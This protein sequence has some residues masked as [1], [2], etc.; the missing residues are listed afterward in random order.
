M[1]TPRRAAIGSALVFAASGAILGAWVSRLPALRD[2]LHATPGQLGTA[3]LAFGVGTLASMPLTGRVVR[4]VGSRVVVAVDALLACAVLA[5]VGRVDTLTELTVAMFVLG[6]FYGSWDVGM[7]VQGST[8]DQRAGRDWMPRY[9]ACWSGGSIIGTAMG[10]LAAG[11]SVG[12]GPHFLVAAVLSAVVCGAGLVLHLDDRV[13]AGAASGRRRGVLTRRLLLIGLIVLLATAIEGAAEDWLAIYLADA[14]HVSEASAALGFTVYAC[15]MTAG[16]FLGTPAAARLGRARAVRLTGLLSVAGVL[17]VIFAPVLPLSYA[18][19]VLWGLGVCLVF[20]AGISAAGESPRPAESIAVV[21]ALGYSSMLVG[22]PLL[23]RLADHVG[24]GHALL[25]LVV[26]GVLVAALAPVVGSGSSSGGS[27]SSSGIGHADDAAESA[28]VAAAVG[29][30]RG[31]EV[32]GLADAQRG[33]LLPGPRVE[34][35]KLP[36]VVVD[37]PDR[38]AGEHR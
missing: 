32:R 4:R 38:A 22:P 5:T 3:L 35:V 19:A 12:V 24:L 1:P 17:L 11:R 25:V 10:A 14:R 33:P 8:V 27:G 21:S 6:V 13:G 15:A 23:G 31:G 34:Q 37:H 29:D 16:G 36:A 7:N 30:G 2:H 20:P 28:D 9:H 26:L 18:G